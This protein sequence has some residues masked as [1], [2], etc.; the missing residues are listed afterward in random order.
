MSMSS[1]LPR[2]LGSAFLLAFVLLTTVLA[3]GQGAKMRPSPDPDQPSEQIEKDSP[4]ERE[5]WFR[6]GRK[7]PKG[8]SAADLLHRAY[9]QKLALRLKNK[10]PVNLSGV[11]VSTSSASSSSASPSQDISQTQ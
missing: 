1:P 3:F 5:A 8:Q 2:R 10:G 7:A 9:K 11:R 6:R 4:Q